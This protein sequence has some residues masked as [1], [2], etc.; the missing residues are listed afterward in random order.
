MRAGSC[1]EACAVETGLRGLFWSVAE[2]R[3]KVGVSGGERPA[4]TS[5]SREGCGEVLVPPIADSLVTIQLAVQT[6]LHLI[7]S[8]DS[9]ATHSVSN[10]HTTSADATV[11]TTEAGSTLRDHMRWFFGFFFK[12]IS[13]YSDNHPSSDVNQPYVYS[14]TYSHPSA[15]FFRPC[16]SDEPTFFYY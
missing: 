9:G 7:C 10:L 4:L 8:V 13:G 15:Q 3:G 11:S 14:G 2:Q 1:R 6:A 5:F 12:V 16:F